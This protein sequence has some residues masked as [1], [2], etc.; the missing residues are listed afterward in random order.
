MSSRGSEAG[1]SRG[2]AE[3]LDRADAHPQAGEGSGP[4]RHRKALHLG[5][6]EIGGL[7][8]EFD[9]GQEDSRVA[10]GRDEA[11]LSEDLRIVHEG[12]ASRC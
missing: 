1:A 9:R 11:H 3:S 8:Q 10:V 5:G 6:F 12:D 2:E 7:Q 4:H